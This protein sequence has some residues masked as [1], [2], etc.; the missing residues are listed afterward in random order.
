MERQMTFRTILA[1]ASGGTASDSAIK[2]TCRPAERFEAHVKGFH[3]R[4]DPINI[5]TVAAAGLDMPLFGDWVDVLTAEAATLAKTTRTAFEA[6][7]ACHDLPLGV[8]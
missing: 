7:A 8:A 4:A 3:V 2:L 6:A 5:A 1:A